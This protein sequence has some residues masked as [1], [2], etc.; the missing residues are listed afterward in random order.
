MI[1]NLY[2][3]AQQ[4]L[5][6]AAKLGWE[7]YQAYLKDFTALKGKYTKKY[8]DDALAAVEA[9]EALPDDQ[10]RSAV[11]ENNRVMVKDLAV[12]CMELWQQL[13]SY[14]NDAYPKNQRKPMLEAAG[15]KHYYGASNNSWEAVAALVNSGDAFIQEHTEA[16]SKE[17]DNMPEDFPATFTAAKDAFKTQYATYLLSAQGKVSGT[18]EKNLANNGVYETLISMLADGQI[19][20]KNDPTKKSLFVFETLL[21][22]IESKGASGLRIV[23][24]EAVTQLPVP[25]VEFTVQPGNFTGSTDENGVLVLNLPEDTYSII[26]MKDGYNSFTEE[27]NVST[28]V[29]S[30]KNIEFT[31]SA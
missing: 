11:P 13:K 30:R 26:G 5:Y 10:A 23:A 4:A 12:Q 24:K 9:A 19:I 15:A 18:G 22:F 6:A 2:N 21:S 25:Q 20:F 14:I 8:G 29:V 1:R 28:G 16:L 3:C 27:V 17:G 7:N 31:K